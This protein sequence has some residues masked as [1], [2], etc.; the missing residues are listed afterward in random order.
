MMNQAVV[1]SETQLRLKGIDILNQALG[2]ALALKFLSLL[3]REA[4]DYVAISRQ[5]YE[6][7]TLEE[8][9]ERASKNWQG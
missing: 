3:Q 2:P 5:L 1:L 4:T 7:Q 6:A 8:I 9:F